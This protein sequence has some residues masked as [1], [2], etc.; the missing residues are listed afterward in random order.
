ML[1]RV[2]PFKCLRQRGCA[3]VVRDTDIWPDLL[4]WRRTANIKA[5]SR[6]RRGD[7]QLH[8]ESPAL[9]GTGR[10]KSMTSLSVLPAAVHFICSVKNEPLS[11]TVIIIWAPWSLARTY[12]V[13]TKMQ[14]RN[15]AA[16]AASPESRVR[17]EVDVL[18]S[19]DGLSP[20]SLSYIRSCY[21]S[22]LSF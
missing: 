21:S 13:A 10:R 5:E 3:S 18:L 17:A 16:A 22:T 4:I 12:D 15:T 2:P 20:L 14:L 6:L 7:G 8:L 11:Q 9:Y 1:A 19:D